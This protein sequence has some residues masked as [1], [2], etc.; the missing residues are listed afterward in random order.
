MHLWGETTLYFWMKF[1]RAT[2]RS[3]PHSFYASCGTDAETTG[4]FNESITKIGFCTVAYGQTSAE[5]F[6]RY[7][8]EVFCD[9]ESMGFNNNLV[10]KITRKE[11]VSFA[12]SIYSETMSLDEQFASPAYAGER[13]CKK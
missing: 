4:W 2:G 9:A 5:A 6:A 13:R 10:I 8:N 7:K 11:Y 12:R 3:A 1:S